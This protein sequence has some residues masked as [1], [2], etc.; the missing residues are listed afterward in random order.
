MLFSLG[1]LASRVVLDVPSEADSLPRNPDLLIR[2]VLDLRTRNAD[3]DAQ[4][5]AY[6]RL[7][8]GPKSE[9]IV[10]LPPEQGALDLGDLSS[11]AV[12]ANDNVAPEAGGQKTRSPRKPAQRNIG[13]LPKHRSHRHGKHTSAG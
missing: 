4:V 8:F 11:D 10:A 3:L 9:R 6:R 12:S 5:A 1:F 2:L 7:V 13:A